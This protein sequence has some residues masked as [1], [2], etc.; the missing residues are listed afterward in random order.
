M[1]SSSSEKC[2]WCKKSVCPLRLFKDEDKYMLEYSSRCTITW[3]LTAE[4]QDDL[5]WFAVRFSALHRLSASVNELADDLLQLMTLDMPPW[6]LE[7]LGAGTLVMAAGGITAYMSPSSRLCLSVENVPDSL[8]GSRLVGLDWNI[9]DSKTRIRFPLTGAVLHAILKSDIGQAAVREAYSSSGGVGGGKDDDR[10]KR[11]LER[12]FP[13]LL[14]DDDS[15]KSPKRSRQEAMAAE[16]E[17]KDSFPRDNSDD[18][19]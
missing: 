15:L 3:E 14:V 13:P 7:S 16:H 2:T 9:S 12:A 17:S 8:D 11:K 6:P 18:S 5:E 10:I 19:D 1:Q 4:L